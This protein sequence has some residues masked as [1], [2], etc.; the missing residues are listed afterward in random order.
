MNAINWF[1]GIYGL[2][3]GISSIGFLTITLLLLVIVFPTYALIDDFQLD[4]LSITLF[5]CAC[6]TLLI[7]WR[8]NAIYFVLYDLKFYK[9]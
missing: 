9:L 1:D 7:N 8:F 5:F 6:L 2:S 3:T 4:L